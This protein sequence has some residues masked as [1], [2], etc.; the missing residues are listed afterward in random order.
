MLR[1]AARRRHG[2]GTVDGRNTSRTP[3]GMDKT[4]QVKV[5]DR[6]SLPTEDVI[7]LVVSVA[8][9]GVDTTY[10]CKRL[11]ENFIFFYEIFLV[12]YFSHV[13]FI[14]LFEY[15][16]GWDKKTGK[17]SW[18]TDPPIPW[19]SQRSGLCI[20]TRS[21]GS[22]QIFQRYLA[23]LC[24]GVGR[25]GHLGQT[26]RNVRKGFIHSPQQRCHKFRLGE[27]CVIYTEWW[28][29]TRWVYFISLALI[30]RYTC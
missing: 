20:S 24:F 12:F 10:W 18:Q 13:L 28:L 8:G 21:T 4:L 7:I 17:W 22:C 29:M 2:I 16:Y 1:Q 23:H 5:Y 14:S 26:K 15:R 3:P 9:C 25:S 30:L 6:D 19:I 11:I 27:I